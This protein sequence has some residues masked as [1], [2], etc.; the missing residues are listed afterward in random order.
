MPAALIQLCVDPRLN[1]DALRAQVR[2]RLG[3]MGLSADRIHLLN[4]VGGNLGANFRNTVALLMKR[5]EPVLLCAVLHHDDCLAAA[6]GLRVPLETTVQQMTR[7]LA[8]QQI[9]CTVLTGHIRTEH[10]HLLWDDEPEI[11]YQPFRFTAP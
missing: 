10:S 5:Q 11:S 8:E 4:E 7:V 1:H 6:E 3:R 9:I 2:Q